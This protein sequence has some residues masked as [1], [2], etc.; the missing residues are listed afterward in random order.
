MNIEIWKK[1]LV[2]KPIAFSSFG[3][4][5]AKYRGIISDA[6]ETTEGFHPLVIFATQANFHSVSTFML[7]DSIMH[8]VQQTEGQSSCPFC[9]EPVLDGCVPLGELVRKVILPE[10]KKASEPPEPPELPDIRDLI[11]ET[12]TFTG[13]KELIDKF[14]AEGLLRKEGQTLHVDFKIARNGCMCGFTY[15]VEK[16]ESVTRSLKEFFGANEVVY[17]LPTR[18]AEKSSIVEVEVGY[19]GKTYKLPGAHQ[20]AEQCG[21]YPVIKGLGM[22]WEFAT[23][24]TKQ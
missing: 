3:K 12:G 5:D 2:G 9:E 22:R 8:S 17:H 1:H 15:Q 21:T 7:G 14:L 24:S 23:P 11:K 10:E 6:V 4:I 19:K 16:I 13:C 20:G 18:T